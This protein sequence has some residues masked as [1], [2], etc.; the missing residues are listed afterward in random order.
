M[1]MMLD[2]HP[3]IAI[4]P[5][6]SPWV[7]EY[8]PRLGVP[9]RVGPWRHGRRLDP[10]SAHALVERIVR[11]PRFADWK[12]PA[13]ELHEAVGRLERATYA[14]VV[15][16][17]FS[18]YARRRGKPRWGDK[19]QFVHVIRDGRESTASIVVGAAP[20]GPRSK[21]YSPPCTSPTGRAESSP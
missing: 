11:H 17:V 13:A 3:R 8:A 21:A 2:Q 5:Q 4:P 18:T 9:G 7:A 16:A 1:R 6:E 12:T 19:A 10:E 20:D 14:G 15:A